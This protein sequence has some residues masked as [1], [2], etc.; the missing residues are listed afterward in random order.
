MNDD[1]SI[2]THGVMTD[3][4]ITAQVIGRAATAALRATH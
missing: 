1:N 4:A 3:S 2:A